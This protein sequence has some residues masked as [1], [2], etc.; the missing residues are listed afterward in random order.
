[1]LPVLSSF[2]KLRLIQF[3]TTVSNAAVL[4]FFHPPFSFTYAKIISP[5]LHGCLMPRCFF[6]LILLLALTACGSLR[7]PQLPTQTAVAIEAATLPAATR[8]PDPTSTPALPTV[9]PLDLP[10]PTTPVT[11]ITPAAGADAYHLKPW[12]QAAAMRLLRES[13][14][15][16]IPEE[17]EN[18]R[19]FYQV[20]LLSEIWLDYPETQSDP[21]LLAAMSG[22]KGLD[23]YFNAYGLM[24]DHSSEYARLL[25]ERA[26][27][28]G[29]AKLGN[30]NA[31]TES[32]GFW[33]PGE[34]L[35]MDNI[36]DT[37]E[38]FDSAVTA[39]VI[40]VR[41]G[42]GWNYFV[43]RS[44]PNNHYSVFA[45]YP[46]WE[47]EWW[48]MDSFQLTDLNANGRQEIAVTHDAWGTGFSH[49]CYEA[50]KLYE[51]DGSAFGNLMA[52]PLEVSMGTDYG[53]C[54]KI[55]FLPGPNG[56][57]S[58]QR[59][60]SG[61]NLATLCDDM[62]YEDLITFRWDGKAY[63]QEPRRVPV[64]PIMTRPS[65][66]SI[67]WALKAGP[68]NDA[69]VNLL[70]SA[71]ADWPAEAEKDW[72]PA[73]RDFFR[74]K[75]AIWQIRRGQVTLG[76]DLL[77]QA[78]AHPYTTAYSLP[79]RVAAIFLDAYASQG[80]YRATVAADRL[81]RKE[82]RCGVAGC[83]VDRM[84]QEQ[85]FAEREWGIE[86]ADL[87]DD[88]DLLNTALFKQS[89]PSRLEDLLTWQEEQGRHPVWSAAGDMD[90]K[91]EADWL[92][93]TEQPYAD[94]PQEFYQSWMICLR[95]GGQVQVMEMDR[96]LY[97]RNVKDN[98]GFRWQSFR[99]ALGAP[100]LN[101]IQAGPNLYVFHMVLKDGGYQVIEDLV[102]TDVFRDSYNDIPEVQ[103]WKIADGQ[104][105]VTYNGREVVYTWDPA[106]N[107]LL[108]TGFAPELQEENIRRAEHALYTD[109]D[110]SR[111]LEI[112]TGMLQG[113]IWESFDPC[114]CG[115]N[116][117]PE[118]L[119]PYLQYLLGLA[120][121][122]SGDS[123]RAT[124]AYYQLWRDYPANPF[125]L[126]AQSKLER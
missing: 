124:L 45:L 8:L 73:A 1:M 13:E 28:D 41:V 26:L 62:P 117:Q 98:Q 123:A 106:K 39:R 111:A 97:I 122:R 76:L 50:F 80:L 67:D 36:I 113:H 33:F 15:V 75:L 107:R 85:G 5:F 23:S 35:P 4:T 61:T 70:T 34:Y 91:G 121:E 86:M 48:S 53:G 22:F 54:L 47:R 119:Q 77:Q 65:R 63:R 101:V 84:R 103:D 109:Q 120:Y 40:E 90:G 55:I 56:Q 43:I 110:P 126:A 88:F 27:N 114:A 87:T 19:E 112:L 9:Q 52:D 104:L 115:G 83:A 32:R 14:T 118:Q 72:G 95:Q 68:L 94:A 105:V 46:E 42:G 37:T 30:L 38:L 93:V 3:T 12:D 100:L 58:P 16:P 66:C 44:D 29:S 51:W 31:W 102:S 20:S 18:T 57:Q 25:L 71:L 116:Q 69:A 17:Y 2:T 60:Q 64:A 89:W 99:P 21:E 82:M 6:F 59:I 108:P 24:H 79:A 11:V 78:R 81:Y 7:P 96:I 125:S 10:T 49:F 74:L 92:V